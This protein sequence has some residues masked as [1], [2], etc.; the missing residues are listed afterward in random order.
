MLD[1]ASP[2]VLTRITDKIIFFSS[3][4]PFSQYLTSKW[5]RFPYID[6][7]GGNVSHAA[8]S[9]A[10]YLGA[11]EI[12][13]LGI[14]FSFP[15]GKSYS[16][17]TYM[18]PLFRSAE[19]RVNP[20]ETLFFSFILKN[21]T[22]IKERVDGC[23]RYTTKPM[24][25]YKERLE[26]FLQKSKAAIIPLPGKG[27]PLNIDRRLKE[28][29]QG[30]GGHILSAGAP[31]TDWK[32]FLK[33]YLTG[34]RALPEPYHPLSGYFRVLSKEEQS[35]WITQFPAATAIRESLGL[36]TVEGPELLKQVREWASVIIL[37]ALDR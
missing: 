26:V 15:E 16:R 13:L 31:K 28:E 27:V 24:I 37:R 6:T 5:R 18:Y 20:L 21:S 2:P 12:T 32:Y 17:G 19:S 33:A 30:S 22:I 25:S 1:L 14:D 36:K 23:I 7:S 8:I 4:H 3:G 9:L 29:K 11:R 35:L 10:Q 34:L